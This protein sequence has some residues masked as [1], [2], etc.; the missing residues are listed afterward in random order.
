M[1]LF[2]YSVKLDGGATKSGSI[3][4]KTEEEARQKIYSL[5]SIAEWLSI[6][7]DKPKPPKPAPVK[8]VKAPPPSIKPSLLKKKPMSKLEK[9]LYLQS[10]KCFFCREAL[11]LSDASIEHL[12][13]RSK[14]GK[15]TDDNVVVCCAAL[16]QTFGSMD[17]R[18]KF[19]FLIS[20]GGLLQ[21]PARS[22][23]HRPA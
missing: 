6:A 23:S 4:A 22:G 17:L 16:N 11:A 1:S 10:G 21:C 13:P 2:R 12:H 20:S 19:D 5:H 18:T 7:A 3:T 15:S 14:G 8:A 9:L